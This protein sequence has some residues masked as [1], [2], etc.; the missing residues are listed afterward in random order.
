MVEFL[1]SHDCLEK[2][3]LGQNCRLAKFSSSFC[4]KNGLLVILWVII[5]ALSVYKHF[6]LTGILIPD[7]S[8]GVGDLTEISFGKI[9]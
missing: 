9:Q 2:L 6:M 5:L 3:S 1:I 7:Y 8:L 4:E